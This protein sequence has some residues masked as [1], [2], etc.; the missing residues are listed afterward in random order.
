[1][2]N[3]KNIPLAFEVLHKNPES[4]PF[5]KQVFNT[6]KL[7]DRLATCCS[8]TLDI[9]SI[10]FKRAEHLDTKA[11][12]AETFGILF[13]SKESTKAAA[14]YSKEADE[15]RSA[16]VYFAAMFL[17]V[18]TVTTSAYWAVEEGLVSLPIKTF[19][20]AA[21]KF[22]GMFKRS[23]PIVLDSEKVEEPVLRATI[24]PP[25]NCSELVEV[26]KPLRFATVVLPPWATTTVS[27]SNSCDTQT[28][29]GLKAL[30]ISS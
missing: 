24:V 7:Y 30:N 20:A 19:G 12:I 23:E 28:Q 16:T 26:E 29:S 18:S 14:K 15:T 8:I 17:V 27:S 9:A 25:P 21:D 13:N 5:A 2:K 3:A 1:M 11:T 10:G 6:K 4:V 22:I